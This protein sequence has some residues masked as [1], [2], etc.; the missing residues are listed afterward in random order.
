MQKIRL[1]TILYFSVFLVA[2]IL[3]P[4]I[5]ARAARGKVS[6]GET[7]ETTASEF[8]LKKG[9]SLDLNFYGASGYIYKTDNKSVFWKTSDSSIVSVSKTGVITGVAP[10]TATIS[11][12]VTVAKTKTSYEGSVTVNVE[13]EQSVTIRQTAFDTFAITYPT[14]E[15]A[16]NALKKEITVKQTRSYS[17]ISYSKENVIAATCSIDEENNKQ[18]NINA[19]YSKSTG[20]TYSFYAEGLG[21]E[22]L[23]LTAAW[24]TVPA[25]C[26]LTYTGAEMSA[27]GGRDIT[28]SKSLTYCEPKPIFL[29]YD[30]NDVIIG[31]T[32]NGQKITLASGVSGTLSFT[33]VSKVGTPSIKNKETGVLRILNMSHSITVYATFTTAGSNAYVR[34]ADVTVIPTE[35]V[36]PELSAEAEGITVTRSTIKGDDISW[37]DSEAWQAEIPATVESYVVFYLRGSDNKKYSGCSYAYAA[38]DIEQLSTTDYKFYYEINGTSNIASIDEKT[39]LLKT[40]DEGD[41]TINIYL[42]EKGKST[43]TDNAEIIGQLYV[44]ITEEPEPYSMYIDEYVLTV[45]A[46]DTSASVSTKFTVYDQYGELFKAE[47]S[48]IR[49]RF[50]IKAA[51]SSYKNTFE[52]SFSQCFDKSIEYTGGTITFD[53]KGME[54]GEYTYTV[55]YTNKAGDEIISEEITVRVHD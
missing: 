14:A 54:V 37:K 47:K 22:A 38:S 2:L 35:Y 7:R 30:K 29:L 27:S 40:Y 28:G 10:G 13:K 1:R 24:D 49:K 45:T 11:M 9:D 16:A 52:K 46:S 32:S 20:Y 41:V 17:V 23:N 5:Q 4:C 18:I 19:S 15:E 31:R 51:D 55:S 26:T 50:K 3:S 36:R 12:T 6:L 34:S 53:M 25:R 39:G 21:D 42:L 48:T 33:L 44:T 8:T 43:L